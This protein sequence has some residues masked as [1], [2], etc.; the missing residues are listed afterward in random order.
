MGH[1]G[2]VDGPDGQIHYREDGTGD[3]LV[4]LHQAPSSSAMWEVV[5]PHFAAEGFRAVAFDLPGYGMSDPPASEPDLIDYGSAI[6]TAMSR[7]A[8]HRAAV[9]GH[10]TGGSVATQMAVSAPDR[11]SHVAVWGFPLMPEKDRR[12]LATEAPPQYDWEGD[13]IVARWTGRRAVGAPEYTTHIA[14]R[15]LIETL[16]AGSRKPYGH[17]AVGRADHAGLLRQLCAPLLLLAGSNEM[18]L[19]HTRAAHELAPD[20]TLVMLGEAGID[21]A[22]HY[23]EELVAAVRDFVRS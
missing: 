22:D 5:L 23:P 11:V 6:L 2:Y 9:V 16:Q 3:P 20:A 15:C 18:L 4:L 1:R 10:H 14:L 13:E 7:L 19:D 8:I 21:V 17:R 12:R